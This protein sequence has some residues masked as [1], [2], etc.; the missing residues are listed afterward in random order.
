MGPLTSNGSE[1]PVQPVAGS[2][3]HAGWAA[4]GSGPG[5]TPGAP[6]A[7]LRHQARRKG[8]CEGGQG[9]APVLDPGLA[10]GGDRPGSPRGKPGPTEGGRGTQDFGLQSPAGSEEDTAAAGT[11]GRGLNSTPSS[12]ATYL[13]CFTPEPAA[14]TREPWSHD[15]P[16]SSGEGDAGS[17]SFP[18]AL[19]LDG[20]SCV[21]PQPHSNDLRS[22]PSPA[23]HAD[24]VSFN[25][26]W[27]SC[28]SVCFWLRS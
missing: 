10:P 11:A 13:Q 16:R 24:P 21:N 12:P 25:P 5:L 22:S 7:R 15:R 20:A 23:H 17:C 8:C 2:Q 3:K 1:R 14:A 9:G 19:V 27:L 4:L 6:G 26:G 18:P 28:L